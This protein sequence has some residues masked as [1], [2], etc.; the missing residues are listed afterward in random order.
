MIGINAYLSTLSTKAEFTHSQTFTSSGTWTRPAG[1]DMVYIILVGAGG[2]GGYTELAPNCVGMGYG[3]SVIGPGGGSGSWF[4]RWVPVSGNV[5][6][7]IG[8]GGVF[9]PCH[10]FPACYPSY[11]STDGGASCFGTVIA[12][13]GKTP[14]KVM[15]DSSRSHN[16]MGY[17]GVGQSM[18]IP[19]IPLGPKCSYT[20]ATGMAVSH[21]TYGVTP[22]GCGNGGVGGGIDANNT[23]CIGTSGANGLCIVFWRQ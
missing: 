11:P 1:V 15:Y 14:G 12:A 6:V 19:G 18:G 4:E 23:C 22:Y 5:T 21:G 2:G 10:M 9:T 3:G 16:C 20:C 7:V 17:Y 8:S 13:G